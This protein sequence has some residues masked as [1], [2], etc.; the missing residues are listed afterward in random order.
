[1]NLIETLGIA[2]FVCFGIAGLFL[3]VAVVLFFVLDITRVFGD[4]TGRTAKKEIENIRSKNV[5]SGDKK[6][7][8]SPVNQA[9]GKLTE[10]INEDGS[11]QSRSGGIGTMFETEKISHHN[12]ADGTTVLSDGTQFGNDTTLLG[13]GDQTTVLNGGYDNQTTVLSDEHNDQTTVLFGG[14]DAQSSAQ[15]DGTV[16]LDN[17]YTEQTTAPEA[18][19]VASATLVEEICFVHTNEIIS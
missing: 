7:K 5:Q 1:M 14:Y 17:Q 13:E 19:T 8:P 18:P 12:T 15:N 10:K 6:Y 16:V 2:K 3:V 9:R 11:V 4:L